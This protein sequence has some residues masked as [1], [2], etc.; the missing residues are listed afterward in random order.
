MSY[1]LKLLDFEVFWRNVF[2]DYIQ[3]FYSLVNIFVRYFPDIFADCGVECGCFQWASSQQ[4]VF[5]NPEVTQLRVQRVASSVYSRCWAGGVRRGR[6]WSCSRGRTPATRSRGRC[7]SSA[8][9][10]RWTLSTA[11]S[12]END[13]QLHLFLGGTESE[14]YTRLI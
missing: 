7:A 5:P 9:R 6:R 14:I 8:T 11:S 2:K 10:S 3:H 4:T 13:R 1:R 12:P